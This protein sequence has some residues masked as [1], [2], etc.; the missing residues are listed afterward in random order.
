MYIAIN[1]ARKISM[2]IYYNECKVRLGVAE[3]VYAGNFLQDAADLSRVE[4]AERFSRQIA[5]NRWVGINALHITINFAPVER[6]D[7]E[8][9]I[10]ITQDYMEG[11]GF[12][13]QPYLVY[14]HFDAGHPHL[15]IVTTNIRDNGDPINLHRLVLKKSEP[16]RKAIEEKYGLVK[17]ER[18]EQ[19]QPDLISARPPEVIQYGKRPT[20]EAITDVLNYVLHQYRYQDLMELNAILKLYNLRANP[21]KPGGRMHAHGGLQY[22][23]LDIKGK[24][25]GT[26]IKTSAFYLNPGL[27]WLQEKFQAN[28]K[29]DPSM[30]MRLQAVIDQAVRQRPAGWGDFAKYLQREQVAA[31]PHLNNQ[32]QLEGM[33]FVDF[34][35]KGVIKASDLW[36][37][38]IGNALGQGRN[39]SEVLEILFRK[40]GLD[41]ALPNELTQQAKQRLNKGKSQSI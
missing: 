41:R 35:M 13:D 14:Q 12:K 18:R 16:T 7:R 38:Q 24:Y 39:Q 22:R 32:G 28:Q 37:D 27:N 8:K 20:E 36:K 30:T 6:Y 26:P 40:E 23:I 2:S 1:E 11:I 29:I 15:H 31:V 17:R 25:I 9:L 3:C 33:S 4:K 5:L 21:G 10:A 34:K 19:Q